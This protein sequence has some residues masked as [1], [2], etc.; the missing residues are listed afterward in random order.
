MTIAIVIA[1][2]HDDMVHLSKALGVCGWWWRG[3]KHQHIT[4]CLDAAWNI[5]YTCI[6][7][8]IYIYMVYNVKSYN[9][10]CTYYIYHIYTRFGWVL[11]EKC[12]KCLT[13][14]KGQKSKATLQSVNPFGGTPMDDEISLAQN[15]LS[16]LVATKHVSRA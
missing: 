6:Y 13:F 14:C 8:Y 10:M 3:R 16:L 9:T 5:K 1:T 12:W 4:P 11:G 7:I 2:M 15:I